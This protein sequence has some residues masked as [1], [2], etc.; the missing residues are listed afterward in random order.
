M[1]LE[2][3]IY[4]KQL[5]GFLLDFYGI[6]GNL[7]TRLQSFL[8]DCFQQVVVDGCFSPPCERSSGVPQGSVLGITLLLLYV[9]D[10][11]EGVHSHIKLFADDYLI[12]RTIHTYSDQLVYPTRP[13]N[14]LVK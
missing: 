13:I 8:S 6:R 4:Q 2:Y 7:F 3:L 5:T 12:Y 1:L 10:K 14:T 9:N 11:P